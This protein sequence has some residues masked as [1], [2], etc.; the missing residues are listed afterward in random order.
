[1]KKFIHK[2]VRPIIHISLVLFITCF[3]LRARVVLAQARELHF[4]NLPQRVIIL[5]KKQTGVDYKKLAL[6]IALHETKNCGISYGAARY[7]NCMGF[8]VS[9]HFLKFKTKEDSYAKFYSLWQNSYG[10]GFPT[11]RQATCWVCGCSTPTGHDC[12]GGSPRG[13]LVSVR[14]IFAT[15]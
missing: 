11:I 6:S 9:G 12:P 5:P 15:L 3:V 14:N 1:M 2:V 8:R 4:G 10:G 7:N 13:W